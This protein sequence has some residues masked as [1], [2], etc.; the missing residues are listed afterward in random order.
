MARGVG[1]VAGDEPD[2]VPVESLEPVD[3]P[4]HLVLVSRFSKRMVRLSP[5]ATRR[6]RL[7]S[8]M[9]ARMASRTF[10]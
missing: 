9:R 4:P 3:G 5:T 7:R 8:M 10:S 2:S 6:L 1:V